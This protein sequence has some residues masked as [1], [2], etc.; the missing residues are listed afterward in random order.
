MSKGFK[1]S[2]SA[3]RAEYYFDVTADTFEEKV[4][5][6]S[7]AVPVVVDFWAKWCG[8]C[9]ALGPLLEDLADEY[10]GKFLLAKVDIDKEPDLAQQFQ[11]SSI[12]LVVAIS[13]GELVTHFM[14]ALPE[15]AVRKF[16]D[17]VIPSPSMKKTREALLG[18]DLSKD[19]KRQL[20]EEAV[21]LDAKNTLAAAHWAD[22]LLDAGEEDRARELIAPINEASDG[23]A[24]S[25]SVRARLSF[26]ES[27]R[28]LPAMEECQRK[29]E[30]DP[31]NLQLLLDLALAQAARGLWKESLES[32]VTVAEKNPKRGN[33]ESRPHM[34]E[35]F[36]ILGPQ[37]P[38]VADYRHRLSSA[39]Y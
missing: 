16:L 13:N 37:H 10:E 32:F 18:E 33:E 29:A 36:G 26:A 19:Q 39:I 14:G 7:F 38:L 35:I 21:S 1:M 22:M 3:K 12:P 20:L 30:A 5:Q 31:K 28:H 2:G 4:I 25:Q 11:V 15:P 24:K 27:A 8:P 23:W 6:Q 17:Q 9:R 34:V